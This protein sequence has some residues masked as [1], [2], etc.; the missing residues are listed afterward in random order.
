MKKVAVAVAVLAVGT[1]APGFAKANTDVFGTQQLIDGSYSLRQS[2]TEQ[3][4]PVRGQSVLNRPRPDF[5]PTPISVASFNIFPS[6]DFGTEYNNNIFAQNGSNKNGSGGLTADSIESV[7]PAVSVLSDWGRHAIALTATG[8]INY[9]AWNNHQNYNGATVQAEGRYDISEKTWLAGTGG[10][11]RVT[12]LRGNPS[13]PTSQAGPSQYNLYSASAEVNRGVGLIQAKAGYSIDDYEYAP[14]DIIGGGSA[15]QSARDRVQNNLSSE[16]SYN[17]VENLKPYVAF[18][19]NWR[20][21]TNSGFR[22]SNGY[23]ADVGA[24]MD[25]GGV[26]TAQAYVGYMEQDYYNF[27]A[28]GGTIGSVDFGADILWNVTELTSIEGKAN[29]SIEET[30]AGAAS[31]YINSAGSVTVSHELK[32]NVV[33]EGNIGYNGIDY[34]GVSQRDEFYNVGGGARYYI[35]RNIHTDLTY[36]YQRKTSTTQSFDFDQHVVMLRIGLQY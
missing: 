22:S 5:D 29:R 2:T 4:D 21:Y 3:F 1:L 13:T 23:K 14:I 9:Y 7:N 27:G 20:D 18:G 15:S 28:G 8:D 11:Q 17:A 24:R 25:F 10:Y 36:D 32:R 34:Q 35:N 33:L 31:S 6:I 30:T 12:E 26:T 19:Y 16:V